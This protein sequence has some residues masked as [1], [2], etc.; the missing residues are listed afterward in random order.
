MLRPK[1]A[2]AVLLLSYFALAQAADP[3]AVHSPDGKPLSQRVVSYT[4]DAHLDV[5]ARTLD[6]TEVLVYRNLTGQPL[7][8]FPFHLYL[9]AF[10][11]QSTW[12]REAHRDAQ[13]D[14]PTDR[15]WDPKYRGAIDIRSLQADGMGDLTAQV[16]FI[17][18]DDGNTGDRTVAEVKLPRPVAPGQSVTFRIA[19]HDKFPET[20]ARNGYKRDFIMG[21]Q[22]FPKVG[23]FW[24]GSWNCHQYHASTEFF[25]DFGAYDVKLTL[26]RN[27]VVGASG[28]LVSSA[29][30]ADGT[31]TLTFHGEDIHDFAWAAS[32]RFVAFDGTF[33]SSLGP[34]RMHALVLRSHAAQ[35]QR[36]LDI[37]KQTL[38]RFDQWYGPYPYTQITLIDPEP[39]SAAGGMEYPTLFTGETSWGMPAGIRLPELVTEHEFGHQYWYGMVATNEFEEAWLDEGINS[40]T[41]G[42]VLDSIFGHDRSVLALGSAHMGERGFMRAEYRLADD[43][44]PLERKAWLYINGS[45]YGGVT[46]AKTSLFLDTL[47]ALVGE[48]TVRKGL[49]T[50]FMRY[51]FHHPDAQDFLNTMQEV[52]GRDLH[53]FFNQAVYGTQVLDYEVQ[54]VSS[55]PLEWWKQEKRRPA[56]DKPGTQYR[57]YVVIHRKGD[58]ILPV[59]VETKFKD[60]SVARETWD[61]QDRWVRYTYDR[62]SRVVSAEIDPQHL[63][64]LDA[65]E[66]NNSRTVA[67]HGGATHKLANYWL[68]LSQWF[69]QMVSWLI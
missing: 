23:V 42:K 64:A 35:G 24:H 28:Y 50:Y 21:G 3:R 68:V 2:F 18:P 40:Y 48:D 56:N 44:D 4:I 63:I 19:F 27:Y 6:A 57:S 13:R 10:Q 14:W 15:D 46:Y 38:Q 69:G 25:S 37:L 22:W 34:V 60:G 41:E 30:N 49:H 29:E 39:G 11:P 45:A 17:A 36:Y 66:L 61:G 52:A 33:Q 32:P 58:F 7:D 20:V 67:F 12:M 9:N 65:H 31:K 53:P 59:Q 47:E 55:E 16:H 8:T 26:A 62:P 1:L 51:R 54:S 5:A 43:T